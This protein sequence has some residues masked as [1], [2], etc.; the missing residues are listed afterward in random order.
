MSA[1]SEENGELF[2]QD[3]YAILGCDKSSTKEVIERKA[4]K[5]G[6]KYH[7]DK[8]SNPD[9]TAKFHL[10]QK[11]K[12]ILLD[13]AKRK[14]IDS[15]IAANL[16]RK[17]F[18]EKRFSSMDEKRQKIKEQ[19]QNRYR[20]ASHNSA[21]KGEQSSNSIKRNVIIE[22]LRKK[23]S[24]RLEKLNE[25]NSGFDQ[26]EFDMKKHRDMMAKTE[27]GKRQI[28][29]KWK[30][31]D[32]SH[33]DDSIYQLFKIFG[34]IEDISVVSSKGTSAIVTFTHE[35]FAKAAYIEYA[36]S[37]DLR[38]TLIA[39]V[40]TKPVAVMHILSDEKQYNEQVQLR[41]NLN[42]N[43]SSDPNL[44]SDIRRCYEREILVKELEENNGIKNFNSNHD[45]SINSAPLVSAVN[46]TEFS[47]KENDILK[48][49]MEMSQKTA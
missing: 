28:K 22:E 18:D 40:F 14:E 2:L 17:E 37:S 36:L 10:V 20:E 31:N 42:L 29:V 47:T 38:V 32:I 34:E 30:R 25:Q 26:R 45:T 24:D 46:Y 43:L 23:N 48:M 9:A 12:E 33:S 44:A 4:R 7:P 11:A 35:D 13:E 1:K 5:L 16:K 6:L 27:V 19:F 41:V 8:T 39:N 3:W 15:H 21:K 49:M